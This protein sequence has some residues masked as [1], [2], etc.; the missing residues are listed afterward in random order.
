MR[1]GEP[2]DYYQPILVVASM[3]DYDG[4]GITNADDMCQ[5]VMPSGVDSDEDGIDDACE[6]DLR[7]NTKPVVTPPVVTSPGEL[8]PVEQAQPSNAV[9]GASTST[10][11]STPYQG[12]II[13]LQGLSNST[14]PYGADE[15]GVDSEPETSSTTTG[16]AILPGQV[17]TPALQ[18]QTANHTHFLWYAAAGAF[19]V[20]VTGFVIYRL[21]R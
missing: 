11:A 5:F 12:P 3:T 16:Q 9:L 20:M 21:R 6:G 13:A 8:K 4:D 18:D 2:V 7:P 15:S 19:V 14:R 10:G 1:S 17:S